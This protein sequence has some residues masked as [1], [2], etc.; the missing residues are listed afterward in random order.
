MYSNKLAV[1]FAIAFSVGSVA[2]AP[3]QT[4]AAASFSQ[5]EQQVNADQ[6]IYIYPTA[7]PAR[8]QRIKAKLLN[9]SPMTLQ[10]VI[11]GHPRE[12]SESEVSMITESHRN[13]AK[14]ALIGFLL[15]TVLD[16]SVLHGAQLFHDCPHDAE[17]C[18]W[19]KL[20]LVVFGGSGTLVG[21]EIGHSI[22]REE[23]LFL[24]PP[25]TTVSVKPIVDAHR[26]MLA[27]TF[28]F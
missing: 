9:V 10:V 19:A 20:G 18:S 11:D 16:L 2:T 28:S 24:P 7:N 6:S 14:G 26:R 15:G 5:L 23:P 22:E 3:A 12:F 27:M 17:S 4:T 1:I 8:H 13:T 25:P 21:A